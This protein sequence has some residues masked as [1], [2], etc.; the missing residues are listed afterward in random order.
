MVQKRLEAFVRQAAKT[1]KTEKDLSL[2]KNNKTA[3]F[4]Y[5]RFND[6]INC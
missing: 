4:S 6:L 3:Y 2:S 1:L 5:Y